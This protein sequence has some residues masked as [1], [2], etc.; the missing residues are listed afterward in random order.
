[1]ASPSPLPIRF[2]DSLTV[3]Y[4]DTIRFSVEGHIS[5]VP[6]HRFAEESEYF[7][8]TFMLHR[9]LD[10]VVS[11]EGVKALQ[12]RIFVEVLYPRVSDTATVDF[13]KEEWLDILHVSS[14]W[15][16]NAIR[17]L[18]IRCLNPHVEDPLQ[19]T[20]VGRSNNIL[21]WFI[22]GCCTLLCKT[23][24]ISLDE[25]EAI[26]CDI[27][28][29]LWPIREALSRQ[30][31]AGTWPASQVSCGSGDIV[32]DIDYDVLDRVRVEFKEELR[33]MD[34]EDEARGGGAKALGYGLYQRTLPVSGEREGDGGAF[35]VENPGRI[36]RTEVEL[37]ELWSRGPRTEVEPEELFSRGPKEESPGEEGVEVENE[38]QVQGM[39]PA[40]RIFHLST[41]VV[42]NLP[43]TPQREDAKGGD[44]D[45]DDSI[46][47]MVSAKANE[48]RDRDDVFEINLGPKSQSHQEDNPKSRILNPH[49]RRPESEEPVPSSSNMGRFR[50]LVGTRWRNGTKGKKQGAPLERLH[51]LDYDPKPQR[52]KDKFTGHFKSSDE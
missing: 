6:S 12:F 42:Y 52:G 51:S 43:T 40:E 8:S 33:T 10:S 21:D 5:E 20:R 16:F 29:R 11:L 27:A 22:I 3:H 15:R 46:A 30:T 31:Q 13:T 24:S 26:G 28:L 19:M 32:L 47:S 34:A 36:G 1:M 35:E 25:A 2:R 50:S 17:T 37:E 41:E 7:S 23:E 45:D 49:Y 9:D 48:P 14:L 18:A 39:Y 44:N 4:G 38:Q